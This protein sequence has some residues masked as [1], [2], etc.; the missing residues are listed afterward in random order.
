MRRARRVRMIAALGA[1][2]AGLAIAAPAQGAPPGSSE[3]TS[4]AALTAPPGSSEPPDAPETGDA[5]YWRERAL[6]AE[7]TARRA[8]RRALRA[9]RIVHRL[10]AE[11]KVLR[12]R[13]RPSVDYA[14]R[15]A[16]VTYAIPA[17][18]MRAVAWCESR[19][20]PSATNESSDAAGLFQFL[21][22]TWAG[23]PYRGFPRYDPLASALAAGWLAQASA[24]GPQW[25]WRRWE[26]KP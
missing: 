19:F 1:A 9:E 2:A 8:T 4:P 17:W 21:R 3:P 13:W 6:A 25:S 14:I 24:P 23:T 18:E 12:R 10:R 20:F 26:C 22:S 16:S 15:V 7:R 11:R 5:E